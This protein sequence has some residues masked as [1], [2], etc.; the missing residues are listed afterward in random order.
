M[1]R[2]YHCPFGIV[3][4]GIGKNQSYISDN[5]IGSDVMPIS[6][7]LLDFRQV[8]RLSNHLTVVLSR[9]RGD[10]TK[11][12]EVTSFYFIFVVFEDYPQTLK[13]KPAKP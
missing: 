10:T 3:S 8:H 5:V 12:C 6:Q 2:A 7:S 11:Y 4:F 13:I 1:V 9:G